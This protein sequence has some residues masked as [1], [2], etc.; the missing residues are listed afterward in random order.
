M[1]N[2]QRA[3]QM[4]EAS[5]AQFRRI[6]Q[7]TGIDTDGQ[8]VCHVIAAKN[9]GSWS[10]RPPFLNLCPSAGQRYYFSDSTLRCNVS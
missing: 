8:D 4:R 1:E 3:P 10:S 5:T 7:Q 9:K 6:L 2:K